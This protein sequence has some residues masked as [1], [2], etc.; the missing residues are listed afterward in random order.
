MRS[1]L[2]RQSLPK[3]RVTSAIIPAAAVQCAARRL[4][5]AG[6]P[7]M[8]S[9]VVA[10]VGERA[11]QGEVPPWREGEGRQTIEILF[12]LGH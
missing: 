7:P 10:G 5:T 9:P 11:G 6:L 2:P 1:S 4:F 12:A 8:F 3:K